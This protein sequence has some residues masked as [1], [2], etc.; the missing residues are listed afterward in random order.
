LQLTRKG[1]PRQAGAADDDIE[2]GSVMLLVLQGAPRLLA[3]A[4]MT[5]ASS[6]GLQSVFRLLFV[7]SS[8]SE[9]G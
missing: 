8:I 5:T 9:E 1:K 3:T 7:A 2:I 6:V 4:L